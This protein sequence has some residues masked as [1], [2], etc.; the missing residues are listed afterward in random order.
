MTVKTLP[1][2]LEYGDNYFNHP[3][4]VKLP[5]DNIKADKLAELSGPCVT[6]VPAKT[7][8]GVQDESHG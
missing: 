4:S 8:G 3:V 2:S 1:Y 5:H 7:E 6:V